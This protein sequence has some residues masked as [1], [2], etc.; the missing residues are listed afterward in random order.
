MGYEIST[1]GNLREPLFYGP[2]YANG[3]TPN[4]H[5]SSGRTP[6]LAAAPVVIPLAV[7]VAVTALAVGVTVVAVCAATDCI[8]TLA[9]AYASRSSA[10]PTV[11]QS[12]NTA[13]DS[14]SADLQ[15]SHMSQEEE[16]AVDGPT[17]LPT[18]DHKGKVHGDLPKVE[19]LGDY[20]TE[21][22]EQLKD[23]LQASVEERIRVNAELG[24]KGGHGRRQAE[25]QDMVKSIDKNLEGR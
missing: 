1:N 25:E 17:E 14:H 8:D 6:A 24:P 7:P 19:D 21:E 2:L 5:D 11:Q 16:M 23:D 22:L 15:S 4:L 20:S 18:L 13:G 10:P 3:N 12:V 9:D